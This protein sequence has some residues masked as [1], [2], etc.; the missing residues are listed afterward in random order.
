MQASFTGVIFGAL[1]VA[2]TAQFQLWQGSKQRE[3][4]LN[5]LQIV[6]LV[7]PYQLAVCVMCIL[8][9]ETS[10]AIAAQTLWDVAWSA[11]QLGWILIT[12]GL[13]I[14]VNIVTYALIGKTV[15]QGGGNDVV[16]RV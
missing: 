8:L 12:C 7:M 6:D 2:S 1:A 4:Q 11:E 10:P 15:G 14:A 16:Q 13:A 9:L 5:P 3:Y